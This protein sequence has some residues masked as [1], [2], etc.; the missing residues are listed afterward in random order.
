[1]RVLITSGVGIEFLL[2]AGALFAR[3]PAPRV[4]VIGHVMRCR[5]PPAQRNVPAGG[6]QDD[7]LRKQPG[8]HRASEVL[9]GTDAGDLVKQLVVDHQSAEQCLLSVAIFWQD[10]RER[11]RL[12]HPRLLAAC[13]F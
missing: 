1:M 5:E 6:D 2:G 9:G 4:I 11:M 8:V 10:R 13:I 12:R 7:E 3:S